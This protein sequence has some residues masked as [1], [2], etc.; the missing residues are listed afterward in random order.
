VEMT[1]TYPKFPETHLT[2]NGHSVQIISVFLTLTNNEE[3]MHRL[4]YYP[5]YPMCLNRDVFE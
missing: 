3:R 2:S 4:H 1:C 5:L